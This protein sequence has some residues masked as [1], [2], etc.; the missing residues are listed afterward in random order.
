MFKSQK[1]TVL[2]GPHGRLTIQL[3]NV[4]YS[5]KHKMQIKH[6][7]KA[8]LTYQNANAYAENIVRNVNPSPKPVI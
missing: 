6:I 1:Q 8:G 3:L 7:V 5:L 2:R 4:F